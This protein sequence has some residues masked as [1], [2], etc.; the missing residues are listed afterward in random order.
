VGRLQQITV[1]ALL[2]NGRYDTAQD[3]V[4]EPFFK[5][6]PRVKWVRFD[7]EGSSHT[8]MWEDRERYIQL[9][10]EFLSE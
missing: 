9:L 2:V 10:K 8:P 4:V 1:P 3:W 6:L 7:S 5:E